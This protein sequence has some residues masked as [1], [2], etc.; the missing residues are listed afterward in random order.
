MSPQAGQGLARIFCVRTI[1]TTCNGLFR[2]GGAALGA[3]SADFQA[4]NDNMK[5]A[6]TLNLAF[7]A[8]E[9]VTFKLHNLAAAQAGHVDVIALWAPF[10]KVLLA[11]HVHQIKFVDQPVTLEQIECAVDSHPVNSRVQFLCMT[12]DLGCIQVLFGGFDDAENGPP[13]MR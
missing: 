12:Q 5:A 13:L 2:R 3:V 9:Q 4:R 1:A 10:V 8:V 7:E 6:V 11:L